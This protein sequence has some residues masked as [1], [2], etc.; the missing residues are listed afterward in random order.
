MTVPLLYAFAGAALWGIGLFGF[1]RLAH[2]LRRLMAFNLMGSGT[3]LILVGLA[4]H[5]GE[6]DPVP[7]ALVLTGIVVAIAATALAV[8]LVRRY[9]HLTGRTTLDQPEGLSDRRPRHD[10]DDDQGL[11]DGRR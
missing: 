9:F 1:I 4:H 7:Q 6:P 10:D 5:R 2:L 8:V 11:E 3:F